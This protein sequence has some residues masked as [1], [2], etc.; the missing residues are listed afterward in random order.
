[1]SSRFNGS[2]TG[3][4]VLSIQNASLSFGAR[5][6]W[7]G[8]NLTVRP[9]EFVA[10]LGANG[11]GKTSLLRVILGQ[12]RLTSGTVTI[13]GHPA[14]RGSRDIGY[15]QQQRRIDP[16]TP[17]RARD[18]V[19]Q[20]L[21]GHRWGI[22]LPNAGRRRR[23]EAM[24]DKVGARAYADRPVGLLSGG[25]QQ[26]VRI[27][28]ALVDDP[29][30]LLCD[31]PL[32]SLD[33]HSQSTTTALVDHSRRTD[34]TAVI[35]VTH[36]INPVLPYVDRVLYLAGGQFRI[37]SIDEVLNSETLSEM[38]RTPIEVIRTD[39]RILVAGL[40]ETQGQPDHDAHHVVGA[41]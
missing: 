9:G 22:G 2:S 15:I 11:S 27:A 16:L 41:P 38:Y 12:Q 29:Q 26:R 4:P 5:R 8:L 20:G 33:P 37:G 25:E 19:G 6:L 18:L 10:V 31:E 24:L 30:L 23:I 34:D 1:M 14:R 21:D 28:Q 7:S 32:L 13:A 36:E 3:I 39:D 35:F 40:P 17:L